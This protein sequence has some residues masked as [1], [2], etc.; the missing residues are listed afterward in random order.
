MRCSRRLSAL[1]LVLTLAACGSVPRPFSPGAKSGGLITP[2]PASGLVVH[3]VSGDETATLNSLTVAVIKGLRARN[4]AAI[5][6]ETA[7]RFRLFGAVFPVEQNGGIV[8]L[9]ITWQ[10]A[11][12]AGQVQREDRYLQDTDL[13]AYLDGDP[14]VIQA[15]AETAVDRIGGLLGLAAQVDADGKTPDLT[16]A[17]IRNAPGDGAEALTKAMLSELARLNKTAVTGYRAGLPELEA[18]VTVTPDTGGQDRV[19]II[20]LLRDATGQE[21]GRLEQQNNV[22]SNRLSGRW[23]V[24]ARLASSAAAPGIVDLLNRLQQK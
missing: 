5:P 11:G 12:P 13:A 4:V 16:M 1:L 2:G 17:E 15:I 10:I 21:R 22:P 24:V 23:G 14:Q 18:L 19:K 20:W 6:Y 3:P 9:D 8:T 7:N